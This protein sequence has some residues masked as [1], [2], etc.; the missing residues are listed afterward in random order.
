MQ[1]FM[2]QALIY[3]LIQRLFVALM[4]ICSRRASFC[5]GVAAWLSTVTHVTRTWWRRV[6]LINLS[7]AVFPQSRLLCCCRLGSLWQLEDCDTPRLF[8]CL[9]LANSHISFLVQKCSMSPL[10]VLSRSASDTLTPANSPSTTQCEAD[11]Q[12]HQPLSLKSPYLA[13]PSVQSLH[14]DMISLVLWSHLECANTFQQ[15]LNKQTNYFFT[16]LQPLWSQVNHNLWHYR[17]SG[18]SFV[19]IFVWNNIQCRPNNRFQRLCNDVCVYAISIHE[20]FLS[21][22]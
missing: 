18:Y 13:E 5:L 22:C 20:C 14:M 7:E 6:M 19:L 16:L 8:S 9:C 15:T 11:C 1:W 12:W 3:I 4:L 10:F 21:L 2:L 17:L